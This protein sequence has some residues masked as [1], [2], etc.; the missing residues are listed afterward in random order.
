MITEKRTAKKKNPLLIILFIAFNIAVIGYTAYVDFSK[1]RPGSFEA[2]ISARNI[3]CIATAL[4]CPLIV[5]F[6]DAA[7]YLVMMKKIGEKV[8]FGDA[9]RVSALGKYYDAV[10][11]SGAGGQPFQIWFLSSRGYSAGAAAAMPLMSFITMQFGFVLLALFIFIFNSSAVTSVPVK[12]TAYIGLICYMI[13]PLFIVFFTAAPEAAEKTLKFFIKIGAKVRI[14]K[15]PYKTY[16]KSMRSLKSYRVNTKAL[17]KDKALFV[18]L[19]VLSAVHHFTLFS[20]PYFV[21]SFFGGELPYIQVVAVCAFIYAAIS[22]ILTPGNSGAAEGSFYA[23]FS[24]LGTTRLF[25][26]MLVW[27][28]ACYYYFIIMGLLVYAY[29]AVK[30]KRR[31]SADNIR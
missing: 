10:T 5:L 22:V 28:F 2:Q 24:P 18:K 8:S 14:I 4:I 17:F 7:K 15:S 19:M 1:E 13:V 20:L 30:G 29:N 25:W 3:I 16:L 9:F 11:P 27:R 31:V 26:A 12:I 21:I 6:S 23:L